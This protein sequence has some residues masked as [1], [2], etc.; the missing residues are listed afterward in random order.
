M[1]MVL[2]GAIRAVGV[3]HH[4]GLT[5]DVLFPS[6]RLAQRSFRMPT[7]AR[8]LWKI[9][10]LFLAPIGRKDPST[11]VFKVFGRMW[12]SP[13]SF[14]HRRN[15]SRNH[16]CAWYEGRIRPSNHAHTRTRMLR[17]IPVQSLTPNYLTTG[18]RRF[19]K[20]A[21]SQSITQAG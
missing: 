1:A 11:G 19:L 5:V 3:G 14:H 15:Q 17:R 13:P 9:F 4:P 8:R 18:G 20:S 6:S 7:C 21:H 2:A 10:V 16:V 12:S